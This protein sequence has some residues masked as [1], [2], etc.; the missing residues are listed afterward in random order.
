LVHR[1]GRLG[2]MWMWSF[3]RV[4]RA[5]LSAW[6][7]VAAL[8]APYKLIVGVVQL[9][10]HL[11]AECTDVKRQAAARAEADF[12]HLLH[13][14][15][16]L[17]AQWEAKLSRRRWAGRGIVVVAGG[18][19]YALLAQRLLHSLQHSGCKLPVEIFYLGREERECTAMDELVE[20]AKTA[21]AQVIFRDLLSSYPT[22][23]DVSGYGYA[24]KA[25]AIVASSFEEVL[26]IDAD[27][28]ACCDPTFLFS[29]EQYTEA[30]ALFWCDMYAFDEK[31]VRMYDPWQVRRWPT[32]IDSW[33][34]DALDWWLL[35]RIRA[36]PDFS[37]ALQ[38]VGV[39]SSQLTCES[40][41]LVIHKTR[42]RRGLAAA[43]LLNM[44]S[45][46]PTV[47]AGNVSP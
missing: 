41:Q 25:L 10:W 39:Q 15:P 18:E 26:L 27:N 14:L 21:C 30:G 16:E 3:Q 31:F 11:Y 12:A 7:L 42:C 5:T 38:A 47:Y 22:L 1:I 34:Q 33:L 35:S 4:S 20:L 8:Y 17:A 2:L 29:V 32:R 13:S 43:M 44:N 23:L 45:H 24:A 6:R 9:W 37:A 19:R 46:R 40:G 28:Q 36:K